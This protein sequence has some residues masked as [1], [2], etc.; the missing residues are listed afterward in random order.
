MKNKKINSG[1]KEYFNFSARE[2]KGAIFLSLIICIQIGVLYYLKENAKVPAIP[3][4][5]EIRKLL[6]ALDAAEKSNKDST[7]INQEIKN[8]SALFPFNPN[9][10][11]DSIGRAIGLSVRQ[12]KGIKNYLNSG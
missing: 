6:L 2:R 8:K 11:N 5:Q 1:W 12:L 10:L 9:M 3:D 7:N 4:D